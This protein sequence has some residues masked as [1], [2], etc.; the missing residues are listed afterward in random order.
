MQQWERYR[1]CIRH[2]GGAG[3]FLTDWPPEARELESQ[4]GRDGWFLASTNTIAEDDGA[5]V[6]IL[7]FQRPITADAPRPPDEKAIGF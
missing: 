6:E 7:W 1:F 3:L 4:L 5:L 2:H